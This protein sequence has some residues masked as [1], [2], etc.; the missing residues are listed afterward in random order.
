MNNKISKMHQE[1]SR[2]LKDPR[3]ISHPQE[4]LGLKYQT[5]LNFW[6]KLDLL[7][8]Y[9]WKV[10]EGVYKDFC[11]NKKSEWE[12]AT[13]NTFDKTIGEAIAEAEIWVNWGMVSRVYYAT[14]EIIE[15]VENPVFL[16]M[17]EDFIENNS[18]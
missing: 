14:M 11:D 4:F 5:V 6:S 15:N 8:D 13:I 3:V 12:I 16:K 10:I 2:R 9:Q 17:F 1:V 18:Q 7:K